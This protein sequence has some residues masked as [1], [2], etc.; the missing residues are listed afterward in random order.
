MGIEMP[1]SESVQVGYTTVYRC[2]AYPD[3]HRDRIGQIFVLPGYQ[4]KG[5]GMQMMETVYAVAKEKQAVD[6]SV[7]T[8]FL[9]DL[10]NHTSHAGRRSD[11]NG[12]Q[13]ETHV[14]YEE[15]LRLSMDTGRTA[16]APGI[17]SLT[18]IF[19]VR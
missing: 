8:S 12:V 14:G 13:N 17:Y 16:R 6:I 5:I 15:P 4:Q 11:G 19:K 7:P 3:R 9:P 10:P 1:F 2:Y 18:L